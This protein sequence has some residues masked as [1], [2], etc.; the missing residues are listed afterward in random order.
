M[1]GIQVNV[2]PDI[3]NTLLTI[4]AS[5]ILYFVFK[6][7]AWSKI[8]TMLDNRANL[9]EKNLNQSEEAKNTSLELQKEYEMKLQEAKNE[10]SDIIAN[11]RAYSDELKAKAIKESKEEAKIEYDKGMRSLDLERKKVLSSVNEDIID[12]AML[13]AGKVLSEQADKTVDRS[14]IEKFVLDMGASNE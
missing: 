1:I 10:A 8:K 12:M 5:L 9:I 11:A 6:R 14:M 3:P 4:V 13:T 7:F 2:I